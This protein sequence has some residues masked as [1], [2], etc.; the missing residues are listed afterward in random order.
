M[1]LPEKE[2]K[3]IV[4]FR[5]LQLGDLLCS[6]PAIRA[7]R[8]AYA[9]AHITLVGLPWAKMLVERFPGY[10]NAFIAFPGYPGLPEQ[11]V[12]IDAFPAFIKTMQEQ[13][14]DLALQM[15][16]NGTLANSI[17]ELFGA[18]QFAGFYKPGNYKPNNRLF[19]EYPEVISEVERHLELMQHLGIAAKGKHL[20]FPLTEKDLADFESASLPVK[21]K[22][23]ICVHPGSR[24]VSRQWPPHYFAQVAD[25]CFERGLQVVITGTK[26]E[27][28]IVDKVAGNMK[29]EPIIAAG[30]TSLGA[31]GVLIKNAFLLL[32][33]C[34]GVSHIASAL[35]IKSVV[36]SLDGEPDR[37]APL[38][39][40]LHSVID[41]TTNTEIENVIAE[42]D[43]LL[44]ETMK[45]EPAL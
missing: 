15:Q 27:M 2:I 30:K 43:R 23:Y 8:A 16:G 28:D 11:P 7:L 24:G 29:Y 14:F 45:S 44:N 25:H 9:T 4:V 38:N 20:E 22:Q 13:Q 21:E 39:K 34:T 12:N 6:I 5:A 26:D 42:V 40:Q 32:S 33:N 19:I 36:I 18:R 37:W 41:W 10:F 3:K 31:V 35:E 1:I 17:V